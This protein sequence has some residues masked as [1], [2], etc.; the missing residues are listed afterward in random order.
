MNQLHKL[1]NSATSDSIIIVGNGPSLN[2]TPL[3]FK[4]PSFAMNRIS[5]IYPQTSWRPSYFLC[6]TSNI[7]DRAWR[8]NIQQSVDLGIPS[9]IWNNLSDYINLSQPNIFGIECDRGEVITSK[10]D[11]SLW[12]QDPLS[13]PLSKFGT[14]ILVAVQLSVF[15][16]YKN[17]YLVGCDLNFSFPPLPIKILEKSC[18]VFNKYLSKKGYQLILDETD[19]NHFSQNY[20][21]PGLRSNQL[22]TNM[23]CAHEVI[24]LASRKFGFNVFNCSLS[25]GL[26][27]HPLADIDNIL[28]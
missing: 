14:S 9:F 24:K 20:G 22:N 26:H 5:L 16:G 1:K 10:P 11:L 23:L 18:K 2:L 19:P 8:N 6:V 7:K 25:D 12:C 17:I 15:M 21:T 27:V 13:T 3:N 4:Y 28:S